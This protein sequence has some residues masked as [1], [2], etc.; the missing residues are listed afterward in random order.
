MN[1]I[2]R[3]ALSQTRKAAPYQSSQA[4]PGHG[5]EARIDLISVKFEPTHGPAN[6]PQRH[7]N[8][9]MHARYAVHARTFFRSDFVSVENKESK[10]QLPKLK[11]ASSS[12]VA[13]SIFPQGFLISVLELY[14]NIRIVPQTSPENFVRECQPLR[15]TLTTDFKN[16]GVGIT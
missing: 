9:A 15:M 5:P 12:L 10:I 6:V 14:R 16:A 1:S 7:A 4:L 3:A 8:Q 11:V 2:D 13:R